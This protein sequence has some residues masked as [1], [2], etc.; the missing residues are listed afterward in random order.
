M[1]EYLSLEKLCIGQVIL[2]RVKIEPNA[3]TR[4][5]SVSA[6]V[7]VEA[8]DDECLTLNS[9][10]PGT[11][12]V[13]HPEKVTKSGIFIALKNGFFLIILL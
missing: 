8:I 1:P 3:L 7:E 5:I 6:F 13:G 9:L 2:L 4:V 12:V 11:V 10:M